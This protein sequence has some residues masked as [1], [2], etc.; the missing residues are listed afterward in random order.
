MKYKTVN[1]GWLKR[2]VE[3]GNVIIKCDFHYTDDYAW[4]AAR[5]YGETEWFPARIRHPKWE[6]C[7]DQF[8][9]DRTR[10]VDD[11]RKEGYMNMDESDFRSQSGMAYTRVGDPEKIISFSIHSNLSFSCKIKE[12]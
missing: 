3:K 1:R 8:G 6:D 11:D 5:N 4:D 2:Q 12:A 9:Y 10:C 7:K